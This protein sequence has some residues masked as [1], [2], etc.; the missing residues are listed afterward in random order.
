LILVNDVKLFNEYAIGIGKN[1]H[2]VIR[3]SIYNGIFEKNIFFLV[4]FSS[5]DRIYIDELK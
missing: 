5:L 4:F 1:V 2:L 3:H